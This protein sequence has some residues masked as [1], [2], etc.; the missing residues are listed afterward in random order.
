M[1]DAEAVVVLSLLRCDARDE[2]CTDV[3][4]RHDRKRNGRFIV[5]VSGDSQPHRIVLMKGDSMQVVLSVEEAAIR[6]KTMNEMAHR[7]F[8]NDA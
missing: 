6:S 2:R 5:I 3:L 4:V 1:L 8:S 7:S